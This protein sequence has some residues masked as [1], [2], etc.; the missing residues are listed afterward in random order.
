MNDKDFQYTLWP[1]ENPIALVQIA[2]GMAEHIER[3]DNFARFLNEKNILVFG[4]DHRGHGKNN[5]GHL[6]HLAD[7]DGADFLVTDLKILQDE[8][9]KEYPNTPL[10][11]LGH[12]MGSFITRAF[13][14]KY[15][16]AVDGAILSGTGHGL[17]SSQKIFRILLK[18]NSLFFGSDHISDF[19][20][21]IFNKD[22]NGQVKNPE[23]DLDWLSYNKENIEKYMEDPNCGFNVS[24]AFFQDIIEL[25]EYDSDEKNIRRISK[26][27][28]LL[29]LAGAEDSVGNLGEAVQEFQKTLEKHNPHART[30][31]YEN[32]RHEILNE[33]EKEKVY[34]D[35]WVFI[36]ET[37][38]NME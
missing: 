24:N 26:H 22:L 30:I 1:V 4:M 33:D 17:S 12:S 34:Q 27:L 9:K 16:F 38:K 10:F 5:F 3:Y 37:L 32:M 8:M 31:L 25:V 35:I 20:N 7:E 29:N 14:A 19:F 21:N 11:L 23:T 15:P 36:D 6:G 28:P 2:H 13:L 18:I